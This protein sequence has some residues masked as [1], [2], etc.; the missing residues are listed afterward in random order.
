M[1]RYEYRIEYLKLRIRKSEE[2]ILEALNNFGRDGWRLSRMYG[3][4][5]LRSLRS[6][7]GGVNF[8]LERE[9]ES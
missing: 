6:W 5:R 9:I 8:L 1:K 4:V 7:R 2:Q 3:S